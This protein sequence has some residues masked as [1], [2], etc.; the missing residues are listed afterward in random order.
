M[1]A[2]TIPTAKAATL[3]VPDGTLHYELRGSGPLL[4]LHAAPMDARS[5]EPAADL[6]ATD[7]TVLT[8]DPRG[9]N[10][11]KLT[12]PEQES[13]PRL[14]ADDLHRLLAHVDLGPAAI[15]GTSGGACSALAHA[16]AHPEQVHTVIAHEP[17]FYALLPDRDA[18]AA[19]V[20]QMIATYAAGDPGGAW[21]QFLAN[22]NIHLTEEEMAMF[23]ADPAPQAAADDRY[24]FLKMLHATTSWEPDLDVLKAGPKVVVGVGA[25]STGELCERISFGFA[26]ALSTEAVT[27]P[28]GHL[29]FL[30]DPQGFAA[31]LRG[32]LS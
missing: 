18:H 22:A 31:T 1:N 6:L 11:S 16:Q 27:F 15:M 5:F 7:F 13:T 25:T 4:V 9:I 29:G 8:T 30:D 28:G 19:A 23:A 3:Q 2:S 32:V 10:R 14:R 24:A 17:A 26:E 12:D 21:Q 20:Q